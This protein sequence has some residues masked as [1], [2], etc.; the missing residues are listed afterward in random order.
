MFLRVI[1]LIAINLVGE[2]L[3]FAWCRLIFKLEYADAITISMI[4]DIYKYIYNYIYT[5][6]IY[7][8]YLDVSFVFTW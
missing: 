3:H 8:Y 1:S 5:Y 6:V 2:I 4:G 7:S